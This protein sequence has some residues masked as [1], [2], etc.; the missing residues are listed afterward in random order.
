[1]SWVVIP[2]P[3]Y[4]VTSQQTKM[5]TS[6][7]LKPAPAFI[8]FCNAFTEYGFLSP[9]LMPS[10]SRV[11]YGTRTGGLGLMGEVTTTW[12]DSSSRS[13]AE[14][15]EVLGNV[16]YYDGGMGRAGG[17]AI[18]P[19]AR[20]P[21]PTEPQVNAPVQ[22]QAAGV[23]LVE[24]GRK[25][26]LAAGR[27]TLP[28]DLVPTPG[29]GPLVTFT[30]LGSGE[31]VIGLTSRTRQMSWWALGFILIAAVGTALA[32]RRAGCKVMLIVVVLFAASLLALWLPAVTDFANGAF[33]AGAAL[34]P[35]YVLIGLV[36]R[37]WNSLFV[38]R[39]VI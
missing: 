15:E 29:A 28:V 23:G 3:G 37:L 20:I 1:M 17:R 27:R 33:T 34:I 12:A 35:L 30:G 10:L 8:Q 25:G 38:R 22:Q 13:E 16:M 9:V 39:T 14:K 2:P 21:A 26:H 36:R 18:P 6:G 32:R 19:A 5:Q 4:V 31:L 11:K 7:L 24:Q